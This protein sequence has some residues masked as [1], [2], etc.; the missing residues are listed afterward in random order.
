M[1]TNI[2]TF[3]GIT[4]KFPGVLA[5]NNVTFSIKKGTVH[6]IVGENGAG[7]STLMKILLGLYHIDS[8]EILLNDRKVV[9]RSPLEA[10]HSGIAMIHQEL[11]SALDLT[12]Y[13][14][15]YLGKEIT[16]KNTSI[17]SKKLMRDGTKEILD[18]I[19]IKDID[20][21]AVMRDLSVAKQ[22]MIEIAKAISYNAEVI[23][24]D[25]PTS[26]I[27][28]NDV[29]TL[30]E[31]IK[32][33]KQDGKTIIYVSHKMEEIFSISDSVSVFR[34]G[35]HINTLQTI[36]TNSNELISLMVGRD[37]GEMF[38]KEEAKIGKERLVVEG[39]SRSG[40]FDDISF[41]L[42]EGEILGVAGLMGAGRSEIMETLFGIRKKDKGKVYVNNKLVEIHSPVT[43][44]KHK[45]AFLTEDR[46][47]S[48]C[49]L[50]LSVCVN[51][52]IA[53]I[54]NYA[55]YGFIDKSKVENS[56][57][58]MIDALS[59]KTP[60]IAQKVENLSG[61][62]QQKILVG[63]WLLT[64]PDILIVD[65]PTRG[66]D[67]GAKAEIHKLLVSL[68]KKGKSIIMISSEMPEVLAMSDRILVIN[69]GK[70]SAI[71]DAK[72]T[73]QVEVMHYCTI[74]K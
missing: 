8:G 47:S 21:N 12:V 24:M 33:L 54:N 51:T 69:A 59:I 53:A 17:L 55:S 63:R 43:A 65:E 40:E 15:I 52:Y 28:E 41:N 1:T 36:N 58:Q 18:Y 22:Q 2:L 31:I 39:L 61:G 45:L 26:A 48:G 19:G 66:I 6:A 30:F 3:K 57:N 38:P 10:L 7:K 44:I 14:N 60:S 62:N 71:L 49:F 20:P 34:D 35:N 73:S 56:T 37:I 64:N 9:L 50:P 32:K 23:L 11:S 67:V 70:V 13:Q 4:K 16:Y 25:E 27:A 29:V 72:K 46:K 74:K 42:K 5:L 68:A